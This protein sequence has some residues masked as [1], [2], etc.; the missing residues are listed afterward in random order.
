MGSAIDVNSNEKFGK[1]G[2]ILSLI[3]R[4]YFFLAS[5]IIKQIPVYPYNPWFNTFNQVYF[6]I[7]IL[8]FLVLPIVSLIYSI[9]QLTKEKTKLAIA[10]LTISIIWILFIV[11]FLRI[12]SGPIIDL[13]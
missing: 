10:G 4:L 7:T 2:F 8:I 3:P 1:I 6:M 9:L 13:R 12:I 11:Y 5:I